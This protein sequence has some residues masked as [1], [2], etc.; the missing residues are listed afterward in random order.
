MAKVATPPERVPLP[1]VVEPSLKVTWP[2]AVEGDTVAV[3]VT[4]WP[5]V[6][7]FAEDARLVVVVAWFTV[8]VSV[9]EV[10]ASSFVSLA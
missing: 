7:G 2:D 8:W 9:D 6:D 10:L 4:L 5:K 3:K 1:R